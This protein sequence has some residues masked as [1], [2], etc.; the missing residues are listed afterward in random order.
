MLF[1]TQLRK[2]DADKTTKADEI[3]LLSHKMH[4]AEQK[5]LEQYQRFVT[6]KQSHDDEIERLT[7]KLSQAMA[8]SHQLV[9][10]IVA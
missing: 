9:R 6:E 7:K 3:E 2:S 10:C 5:A 8:D 1:I 4:S